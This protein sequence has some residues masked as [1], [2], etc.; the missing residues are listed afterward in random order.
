MSSSS[1]RRPDEPVGDGTF[2]WNDAPLSTMEDI[3][4]A[5]L[6][7]SKLDAPLMAA[8]FL[9]DYGTYIEKTN[10]EVE[11]GRHVAMQNLGYYAGYHNSLERAKLYEVF[12]I[13]H[14]FFGRGEPT[15]EEAFEMGQQW[16]EAMKENRP[17]P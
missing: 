16:G 13:G 6:A 14:P 4:N 5:A 2:V 1:P 7:I 12:D 8:E 17:L 15:P 9:D 3:W 11:D 10:P